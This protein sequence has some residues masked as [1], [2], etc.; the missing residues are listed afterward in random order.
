MLPFLNEGGNMFDKWAKSHFQKRYPN[1]KQVVNGVE[2]DIGAQ[3][4]LRAGQN[5]IYLKQILADGSEKRST[6]SSFN[7]IP[8]H[9]YNIKLVYNYKY[10]ANELRVKYLS[11]FAIFLGLQFAVVIVFTNFILTL[12]SQ[13]LL[14]VL[15]VYYSKHLFESLGI[16][17]FKLEV[18]DLSVSKK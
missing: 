10:I 5:D 6:L 3:V 2:F 9:Q 15:Y 1:L 4:P 14:L 17:A 13:L 12:C 18:I 16:S 11:L 7:V 8:A